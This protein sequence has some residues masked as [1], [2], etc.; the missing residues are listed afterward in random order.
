MSVRS[1]YGFGSFVFFFM[2]AKNPASSLKQR[3]NPHYG[4]RAKSQQ[5]LQSSEFKP[6]NSGKRRNSIRRA[7]RSNANDHTKQRKS[8][9]DTAA[10]SPKNTRN[11]ERLAGQQKQ[12]A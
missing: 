3:A 2:Q 9:N 11:L 7:F 5:H 10:S 1:C 4:A 6:A 12:T 8:K